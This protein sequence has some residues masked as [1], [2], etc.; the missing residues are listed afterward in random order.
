MRPTMRRLRLLWRR[1]AL[2]WVGADEGTRKAMGMVDI[3]R[4]SV[5][6]SSSMPISG[7]A[8][9]GVPG[10]WVI[11]YPGS[12]SMFEPMTDMQMVSYLRSMQRS[13]V[14]GRGYSLGYSV[15]ASQSGSLWAA[16]GIEGYPGV[17]VY[18]PA[19]NPGKKVD[20][21]FN[22]VSRSIQ[23]AV[24]GQNAASPAAVA[25]VN[26]LIATQPTWD[27]R[28]HSDVDYTSCAGAGI[29][30][31]VQSGVIGHQAAT[32]PSEDDDMTMIDQYRAADTRVWPKAKLKGGKVYQFEIGDGVPPT[33]SAA[34]ATVTVTEPVAAGHV[35]VAKPGSSSLG[36]TSCLNFAPR[37]TVANTTFIPLVGGK[38]DIRVTCDSHVVI[39]VLG[40]VS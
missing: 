29:T 26:A 35:A 23:I 24:G 33:A 40:F 38:F 25:S 15:I 27:V 28:V 18:N 32:P 34:I 6:E 1:F 2:N 13:Y 12:T 20:G 19:S 37:Q 10:T 11:H 5:W 31:Q 8:P 39:D 4:Q 3:I 14:N 21:N 7:P 16:R 36:S 9:R 30:A 22:H 17:R